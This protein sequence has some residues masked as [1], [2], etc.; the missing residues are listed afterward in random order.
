MLLLTI[1]PLHAY[2]L[3]LS[4]VDN[5]AWYYDVVQSS[6]EHGYINGYENGTFKPQNN[7]TYGE[8]YKMTAVA[9]G[10]EIPTENNGGHWALP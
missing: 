2:A 3:E 4:D 5:N 9:T 8:F 10:L 6:V 1:L 7:V